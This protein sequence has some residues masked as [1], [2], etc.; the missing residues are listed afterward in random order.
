MDTGN[1][2]SKQSNKEIET[3]P[4]LEKKSLFLRFAGF[5]EIG[6]IGFLVILVI[7]IS[8]RNPV[9]LSFD[10]LYDNVNI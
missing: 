2:S 7:F 9:F 6:I 10:N 8:I 5:R 3:V 1:K 4:S